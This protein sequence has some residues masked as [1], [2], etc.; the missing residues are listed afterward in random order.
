MNLQDDTLHLTQCCTAL[1][2]T[3]D[4]EQSRHYEDEAKEEEEEAKSSI[5]K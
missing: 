1:R 2:M 5:L 3:N 4:N